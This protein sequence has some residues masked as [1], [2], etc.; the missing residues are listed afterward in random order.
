MLTTVVLVL[1]RAIV[2]AYLFSDAARIS[3]IDS[4][5]PVKKQRDNDGDGTSSTSR[6]V[7]V[8]H[9]AVFVNGEGDDPNPNQLVMRADDES[10]AFAAAARSGEID[11]VLV[12][13]AMLSLTGVVVAKKRYVVVD[14]ADGDLGV[15]AF[16]P[17]D[18]TA[19]A[20]AAL[21]SL[22]SRTSSDSPL[23][24]V[25]LLAWRTM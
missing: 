13:S 2:S 8:Y 25:T 18:V 10:R 23:S 12:G 17:I 7:R 6:N 15:R 4:P 1:A 20:A 14:V 19:S 24:V 3:D 11:A 5:S 16:P 22:S 9:V 21:S